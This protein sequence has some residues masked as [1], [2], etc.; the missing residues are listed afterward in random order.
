[1]I[2]IPQS[3]KFSQTNESDKTGNIYITKNMSFDDVGYVTLADRTVMLGDS[4][5]LTDLVG[6]AKGVSSFVEYD[7]RYWACGSKNLYQSDDA[8]LS[9]WTIDTSTGTPT[10]NTDSRNDMLKWQGHLYVCN[11]ANIYKF[12]GT[13]TWTVESTHNGELL[14]VFE[15]LDYLASASDDEVALFDSAFNK[16]QTLELPNNFGVSSMAW[17]NNRLY[18]GTKN[19]EGDAILFEWDGLTDE[20]NQ[21]YKI[22]GSAILSVTPYKSG[23]AIMTS[24]GELMFCQGGLQRLDVLPVFWEDEDWRSYTFDSLGL[25]APVAPRGM[26]ADSENI[27]IGIE[28]TTPNTR[29]DRNRIYRDNEFISGVWCYTPKVGL[30]QKYSLGSKSITRTNDITTGNVNTTT[31]VITVSATVPATGTPCFYN[32][33]FFGSTTPIAGLKTGLAY[34]TIYVSDTTLKLATTYAN[35]IAGIAIDLTGTGN[36]AQ[37][38][39]FHP[40]A[41]FGGIHHTPTCIIPLVDSTYFGKA[42]AWKFIIGGRTQIGTDTSNTRGSIHGIAKYQ[43]NR[44]YLITP[45]IPSAGIADKLN[46]VVLKWTKLENPEDKFI[47]KYRFQDKKKPR[48]ISFSETAI[49]WTSSTTFTS[50][51]DLSDVVVGDEAEFISGAGAGYLAH[52]TV[53]SEASGTYTVTIDEAIQNISNNDRA[54]VLFDN[55]TKSDVITVD[56]EDNDE[57][58][59]NI[60]IDSSASKWFQVKIELRGMSTRIEDLIINNNVFLPVSK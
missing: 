29:K 8:D 51:S 35:A 54:F 41:D 45:K 40:N 3:N 38:I 59:R 27:Y 1:M 60:G 15:N 7:S 46:S 57:G 20:A 52:V 22:S 58:F 42:Y 21:G 25:Y 36:N 12:D 24:R 55:W 2:Q 6:S 47:I 26:V 31:D 39:T 18:V 30:Q 48:W 11:A 33:N 32:A 50:T 44:G 14:C 37:Y 4:S 5:T 49:T 16:I 10:L 34:F 17:N 56:S 53:I 28:A 9:K 13:D 23:V 19:T 43:E